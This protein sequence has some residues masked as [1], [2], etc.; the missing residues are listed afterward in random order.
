[1]NKHIQITILTFIILLT[2]A[3]AAKTALRKKHHR[4]ETIAFNEVNN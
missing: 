4:H 2:I 3:S 1:M